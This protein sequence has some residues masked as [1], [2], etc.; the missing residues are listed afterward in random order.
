[1]DAALA[2]LLERMLDKSDRHL[3]NSADWIS[4]KAYR[5]AERVDTVGYA[6][7]LVKYL[8]SQK[9]KKE[10]S[11]AYFILSHLIRNL[12]LT[13][14][15]QYLINRTNKED[16][17]YTLG[18]LLDGIALLPKPEQIDLRPIIELTA[19]PK[20]LIRHSAIGAL[21]HAKSAAAERALIGILETS[22]DPYDLTYANATL[23]VIGTGVSIPYLEKHTKSRK[24]DVRMSATLA[25][26]AIIR[27]MQSA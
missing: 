7:Q 1:M 3:P 25:I 18:L 22:I 27:R 2:D 11:A 23:N 15:V 24:R 10:R 20:W 5:E 9:G 17:K 6:D 13:S 14:H 16:D 4:W 21:A 12:Q 26:E 8:E 19:H